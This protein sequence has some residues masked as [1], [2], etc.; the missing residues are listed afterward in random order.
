MWFKNDV[1]DVQMFSVLHEYLVENMS[2]PSRGIVTCH[3][4]L[5][6]EAI[7]GRGKLVPKGMSLVGHQRKRRCLLPYEVQATKSAPRRPKRRPQ[8]RELSYSASLSEWVS[9]VALRFRFSH[10]PVGHKA[11][12]IRY[13][14]PT[15]RPEDTFSARPRRN[16]TAVW[17]MYLQ[18]KKPRRLVLAYRI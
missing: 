18:P 16:F 14:I 4:G 5:S 17:Y 3:P 9:P 8:A 11:S 7:R 15:T 13:R 12:Y 10:R 6:Q 1:H 2:M